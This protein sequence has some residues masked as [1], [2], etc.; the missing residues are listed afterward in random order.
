MKTRVRGPL[1]VTSRHDRR[2]QRS[3]RATIGGAI[4]DY[5]IDWFASFPGD[6]EY[7]YRCAEYEYDRDA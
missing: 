1:S 3:V 2:P 5:A 6:Y 4:G 7:K